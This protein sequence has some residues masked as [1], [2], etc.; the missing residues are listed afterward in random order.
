MIAFIQREQVLI[1]ALVQAV[2]ALGSSFG[3]H[4][5]TEQ[6][7]SIMTVVVLGSAVLTRQTSVPSASISGVVA[8]ARAAGVSEGKSQ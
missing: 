1:L 4:L 7:G 2:I 6:V 3:L 8:A 5:T